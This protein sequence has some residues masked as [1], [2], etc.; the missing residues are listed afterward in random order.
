VGKNSTGGRQPQDSAPDEMPRCFQCAHFRVSGDAAFPRSCLVFGIK[1]RTL[2]AQEV[3]LSTGKHC[4]AFSAKAVAPG[5]NLPYT[6][7]Q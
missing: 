4:P 1:S 6:A 3:F 7:A 2:P 5:R